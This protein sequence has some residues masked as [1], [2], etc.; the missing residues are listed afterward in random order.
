MTTA[1]SVH[2]ILRISE[3][4]QTSLTDPINFREVTMVRLFALVNEQG[5]DPI[6]FRQ[7][8]PTEAFASWSTSSLKR[9]PVCAATF[10][11]RISMRGRI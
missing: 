8:M 6:N 1:F 4:G 3:G 9:T 7:A 10:W 11:K 2:A 5:S